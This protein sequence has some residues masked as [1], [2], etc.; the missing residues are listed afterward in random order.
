MAQ[1]RMNWHRQLLARI[2]PGLKPVAGKPTLPYSPDGGLALKRNKPGLGNL[3]IAIEEVPLPKQLVIPLL[4]YSRQSLKPTVTVGSS[5]NTGD[6]I[7]T[8]VLTT[9]KG[10]I[11]AIEYRPILHPSY[12]KAL[13]VVIDTNDDNTIDENPLLPPLEKLTI[14]RLERAC[15]AGLGGAG[16]STANKLNAY[17]NDSDNKPLHTLLVNAVECEPLISC[18]EALIRSNANCVVQAVAALIELSGC[19][20]CIIAMEDDKHQAVALLA[21]AIAQHESL[22]E[23]SLD[24]ASAQSTSPAP[25]ELVQLSAI[26]PSGAEK[27][28]IQRITG[29]HIQAGE[30]ATDLGIL[31]LNVA[32]VLAAWRAQHGH[33]MTSRIITVAGSNASNPVNVRVRIGTSIAHVLEY[34]GNSH[35]PGVSRVRAGGPLSGFD[36]PDVNVPVTATTNCIA[37]E[38]L[39][40]HT[41]SLPCIRCSH[42]SDVCPV[43]LI[44]QQLHWH[45]ISDNIDG[46]LHFG[47]NSC[48]ECGCCDIVCPSSIELTST[49]RY[50]RTFWREREYQKHESTQARE[51]YERRAMRLRLREKE[52]QRVREQKKDQLATAD[53]AI[54]AAM[55]RARAR[56]KKH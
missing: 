30:K 38:P 21:D 34:T 39:A 48:I 24:R 55:A 1:A 33:P 15:V 56:K 32:T 44:P 54:A 41:A 29:E 25:I 7:A 27:V 42:C 8:D 47:L 40:V 31:C 12:R 4:D 14:E 45:A 10:T 28:L 19:T 46:A 20:R 35:Q 43:N 36:L 22:S 16:F 18:D 23:Y 5:V 50:A 53:D 26:Y 9:A 49:F 6:L 3:G 37:I 13:C 2:A 11:S 17:M 52:T 51:R